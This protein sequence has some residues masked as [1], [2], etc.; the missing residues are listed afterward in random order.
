MSEVL[1]DSINIEA[2][3][4]V[5][6]FAVAAN[7]TN[8]K[9]TEEQGLTFLGELAGDDTFRA[10]F[11]Q[12]PAHALSEVVPAQTVVELPASCLTP[13]LLASKEVMAKARER[14][15]ASLDDSVLNLVVPDSRL[16]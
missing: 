4:D 7:M 16:R 12:K 9:L 8:S 11:E 10:R 14:L 13:R 6:G 1:H 2:F 15:A 3:Q 5:H